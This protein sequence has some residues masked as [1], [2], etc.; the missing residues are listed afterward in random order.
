MKD[1][2]GKMKRKLNYKAMNR[3]RKRAKIIDICNNIY[4]P[5]IPIALTKYVL[6]GAT[7]VLRSQV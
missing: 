6:L 3:R 2:A 7:H 4:L 5:G 1:I